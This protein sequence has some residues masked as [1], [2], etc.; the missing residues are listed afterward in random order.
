MLLFG[1]YH[2][3][4]QTSIY[5]DFIAVSLTIYSQRCCYVESSMEA[6]YASTPTLCNIVPRHRSSL[7]ALSNALTLHIVRAAHWQTFLDTSARHC[8]DT[9]AAVQLCAPHRCRD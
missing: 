5:D 1:M 6:G 9:C 7:A 2:Y 3:R 8:H 4:H